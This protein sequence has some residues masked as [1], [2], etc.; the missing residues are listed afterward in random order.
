MFGSISLKYE[1]VK[2][3][4][5]GNVDGGTCVEVSVNMRDTSIADKTVVFNNL[6]A[7]F[8]VNVNSIEPTILA[9]S[10]MLGKN[11]D[12]LI[13]E[14][15]DDYAAAVRALHLIIQGMLKSRKFERGNYHTNQITTVQD[16]SSDAE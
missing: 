10:L 1:D 4:L 2:V 5:G 3:G 16:S 9:M 15:G 7:G 13:T 8:N 11:A 14:Y 6:A 12:V